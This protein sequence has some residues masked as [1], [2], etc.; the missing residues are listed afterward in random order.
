TQERKRIL[1]SSV[2]GV[3]I[4]AQAVE[5]TKLSLLLKVLEGESQE[6]LNTQ[7]SFLQERA[8]P[9]LA[10]NI[11]CGNSLVGT[12][13]YGGATA[14]LLL[15]DPEDSLQLNAFDWSSEF[16][17]IMDSGGFHAVVGN[18]PYDVL[19]K[20]RGAAS[21]P[22]DQLR[23]YVARTKFYNPGLGGKLNLFRLF[24][25]RALALVRPSGRIGMIVPLALLAD[26]SSA[27]SRRHVVFSLSDLRADCFPQKDNPKR[28]IFRS[29]KLSTT[30]LTGIATPPPSESEAKVNVRVY[31]ANRFEDDHLDATVRWL[32]A[33]ILD[34]SNVPIP[35]VDADDWRLCVSVHS[36]PKVARAGD[37]PDLLIHRGEINQTIY[38]E[39]ITD[40]SSKQRMLKGAEV[41]RYHLRSQL[42]QGQREWLDEDAFLASNTQ[43]SVVDL[44]RIAT[45]R[46]TGIDE[47]RRLVA[48]AV[49]PRCYFADSTNSVALTSESLYAL[50]FVLALLNSSLLQWRFRLTSTNN[51][52]G[53]NELQ[54]LPFRKI[55]FED[56]ADVRLH[57]QVVDLVEV[58][59]KTN[60]A[61]LGAHDPDSRGAFSRKIESL[62]NELD[63]AVFALYGLREDEAALVRQKLTSAM[64]GSVR[65]S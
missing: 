24:L 22:H 63:S 43:R 45:Q 14:D 23:E 11:K 48:T 54:S 36:S 49:E 44:R 31:P 7:L 20:K 30:V 25:V 56:A 39:F 8:L 9:D 34:P 35:L 18:P 12:D 52:V 27:S 61:L 21:W 13:F 59:L 60:V 53:T 46:I 58:L 5:V 28:R 10:E 15:A 1:L 2:F 4:D 55:D 64:A 26:S 38:R 17:D 6:T 37:V 47:R 51:N 41:G 19:E 62:E 29:A 40:D 3:D 42:S 57:G 50:E 16:A 33:A 65:T 32:D